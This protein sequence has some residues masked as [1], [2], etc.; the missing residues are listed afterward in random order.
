VAVTVLVVPLI[1]DTVPSLPSMTKIVLDLG[2]PGPLWGEA[3]GD[4][5]R[6]AAGLVD[7]P[8]MGLAS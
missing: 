7:Y 4:G 5:E 2:W 6:L 1:T 8:A 3:H